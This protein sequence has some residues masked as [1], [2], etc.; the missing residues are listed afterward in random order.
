LLFAQK[1]LINRSNFENQPTAEQLPL[2]AHRHSQF[3]C[4]P[5]TSPKPTAPTTGSRIIGVWVNRIAVASFVARAAIDRLRASP[6]GVSRLMLPR[7][8]HR[9]R[10]RPNL[11]GVGCPVRSGGFHPISIWP[12]KESAV[13][14][15]N[16][17]QQNIRATAV[18][19]IPARARTL[20]DVRM[21]CDLPTA[22]DSTRRRRRIVVESKPAKFCRSIGTSRMSQLGTP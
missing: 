2:G 14:E 18:C 6:P 12:L 9:P 16:C 11:F 5:R 3:P 1:A 20:S 17:G 15:R 10:P 22:G 13:A 19:D 4:M 8:A 7:D 21:A